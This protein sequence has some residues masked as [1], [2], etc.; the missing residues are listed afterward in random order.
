MLSMTKLDF[1]WHNRLES[2]IDWEISDWNKVRVSSVYLHS[3]WVKIVLYNF[4]FS[5]QDCLIMLTF[6]TFSRCIDKIV[7]LYFVWVF[8]WLLS[9]FKFPHKILAIDLR[10]YLNKSITVISYLRDVSLLI[11]IVPL[12]KQIFFCYTGF[13]CEQQ[14]AEV[15]I[16]AQ[17]W[18]QSF[19]QTRSSSCLQC[20]DCLF[21]LSQ[22]KS[23][24]INNL[25]LILLCQLKFL[26][27]VSVTKYSVTSKF[28]LELSNLFLIAFFCCCNIT[29]ACIHT[30]CCSVYNM[31]VKLRFHYWSSY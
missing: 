23:C 20:W 16:S 25:F 2:L 19:D 5:I 13:S 11:K 15:H 18:Y 27:Y 9:S 8:L 17:E 10:R 29:I 21:C 22:H 26:Y 3:S 24:I 6:S 28:L 14:Y 31:E 4:A 30:T 7:L 1:E 12:G